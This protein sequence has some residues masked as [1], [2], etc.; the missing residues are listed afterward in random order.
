MSARLDIQIIVEEG[1]F[2]PIKQTID[3]L[4]HLMCYREVRAIMEWVGRGFFDIPEF[5]DGLLA[6]LSV[7]YPAETIWEAI[8]QYKNENK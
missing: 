3:E 8:E 7:H 5:E 2:K 4:E 6:I 1:D